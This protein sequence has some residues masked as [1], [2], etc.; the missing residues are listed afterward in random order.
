[1]RLPRTS[2]FEAVSSASRRA[3]L[4]RLAKSECSVT[5]LADALGM[6]LPAV[7]QHLRILRGAGL[8]SERPAGRQRLYR[9]TPEPLAELAAWLRAYE[10]V[11]RERSEAP[12][13]AQL[14]EHSPSARWR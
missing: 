3:L 14:R 13:Y 6:T 2:V 5:E 8:V 12:V 10:R 7:S 11:R 1:M 9:L 4:D